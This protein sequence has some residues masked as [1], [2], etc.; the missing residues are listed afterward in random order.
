MG[1]ETTV[2]FNGYL[3]ITESL[4]I[5]FKTNKIAK[6]FLKSLTNVTVNIMEN[7]CVKE[8]YLYLIMILIVQRRIHVLNHYVRFYLC[9]FFIRK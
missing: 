6:Q 7:C 9:V 8:S 3:M 1:N 4:R 2:Y 5:Q